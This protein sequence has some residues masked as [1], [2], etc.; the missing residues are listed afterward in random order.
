[1]ATAMAEAWMK[2]FPMEA[3]PKSAGEK[4]IPVVD[5]PEFARSWNLYRDTSMDI[6]KRFEYMAQCVGFTDKD[7]E[8]I[9][10][11][12][13]LIAANL[14]AILDH[15]YWEKL[16]GDPWLSQWFRDETGQISKDYVTVRRARQR[17]F[18]LKIL[19]CKWDE[20]FLN[21]VR[22]VGAVHVPIFG[23]EDLYIPVRLNLGLMGY[24]HQYFFNF[25]AEQLKDDPAKL[26]R[27]TSA[28]T[29]LFWLVIDIYHIDYFGIWM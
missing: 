25:F 8:A 6:V 1:M 4:K 23:N 10:E 16:I 28:W 19:E 26:Q 5:I 20:E 21:F 22:W 3:K 7:T 11:S 14:E 13:E 17:R 12:K 2:T 29:K 27:I 15:I 9:K 18:L 24:L